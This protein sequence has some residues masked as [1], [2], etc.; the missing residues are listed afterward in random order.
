MEHILEVVNSQHCFS[1]LPKN[2]DQ[3]KETPVSHEEKQSNCSDSRG[4]EFGSKAQRKWRS[5]YS[6]RAEWFGPLKVTV[7][8]LDLDP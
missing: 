7:R 1:P 3:V 2:T 5:G 8:A 4:E 6:F